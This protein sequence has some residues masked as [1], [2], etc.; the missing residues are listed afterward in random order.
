MVRFLVSHIDDAADPEH[1]EAFL[2]YGSPL[3]GSPVSQQAYQKDTHR[4]DIAAL[5]FARVTE[6][7]A[8]APAS[9]DA[10]LAFQRCLALMQK[11]NIY[12]AQD[13]QPGHLEPFKRVMFP[14]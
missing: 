12:E 7:F 1:W 8:I 2:L 13:F 14:D 9:Y 6:R 11:F 3:V 10:D 4:R 5:I